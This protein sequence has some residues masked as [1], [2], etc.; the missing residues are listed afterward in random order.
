M[1]R[2]MHAGVTHHS[3]APWPSGP[4]PACLLQRASPGSGAWG[5]ERVHEN[6]C[7]AILVSLPAPSAAVEL[8][9]KGYRVRSSK[10]SRYFRFR[11][12][13]VCFNTWE[14]LY[15]GLLHLHLDL[16]NLL[17]ALTR[18]TQ[19]DA[20]LA[21]RGYGRRPIRRANDHIFSYDQEL[22][23]DAAMTFHVRV[24]RAQRGPV[25]QRNC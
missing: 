10:R 16:G 24:Q 14:E 8:L 17:Q 11:V 3:V 22:A 13:A 20:A 23:M 1:V 21:V 5:R 19:Q 4:H 6:S 9:L 7:P 15:S 2:N 12:T 18:H 25:R